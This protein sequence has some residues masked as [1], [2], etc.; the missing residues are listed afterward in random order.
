MKLPAL[1]HPLTKA[2][3]RLARGA[4]LGAAVLLALPALALD[5]DLG[6]AAPYSVYV[7]E[8]LTGLV[9]TPGRVA[10]GG[11]LTLGTASLGA[12]LAA[13]QAGTAT[14]LVR[15]NIL[16]F[17][18]PLQLGSAAGFGQYIGTKAASV[19]ASLDLRKVTVLPVDFET[20]RVYLT[21]LS[22]QLRD[23]PATGAVSASGSTL[24]LSGG[25]RPLE[26]FA[27][28]AAQAAAAQRVVMF[29]VAA[30][31]HIVLNLTADSVRRIGFG[32]DTSALAPWKGRVLFNAHDA[33]TLQ[34]NGLTLWGSVLATNACIC[35]STGALKGSA[36]VRKWT[37]AMTVDYVPFIP[38][39]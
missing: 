25:N 15:G 14:L 29:N 8:D 16:G 10:V 21:A 35:T 9:A 3:R 28:T 2:L 34:F 39:P 13:D 38:I 22:E 33:E 24:T 26:V 17:N 18:G 32:I 5:I 31:A 4:A 19:P 12:G 7:F 37:A 27:L 6:G 36:V 20:D 30:N 11:N 23:L 1:H